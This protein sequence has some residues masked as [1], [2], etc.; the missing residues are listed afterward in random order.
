M[1]TFWKHLIVVTGVKHK[2]S[3]SYH[4]QTNGAS[5]RTNKTVNQLLRF[6]VERNQRGWA[7][8]LPRI[9][10]QIMS[11]VNKSTGYT[12]FQ[13]R[14]GRTPRIIPPLFN[15]S[16]NASDT[17]ISACKIIHDVQMDVAGGVATTYIILFLATAS[18]TI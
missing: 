15:L 7:H 1:S 16:P 8:A 11:T 4:P 18:T 12:P 17:C 13:L 14:F 5:K 3:S 2:V 10:F 9:R 6:Y